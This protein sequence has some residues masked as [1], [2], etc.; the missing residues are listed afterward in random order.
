M[1]SFVEGEVALRPWPEWVADPQRIV[2]VARLVRAYDDVV[3]SMGV[4]DW[5]R[6]L[7]RPD[8]LGTPTSI[9]GASELIGHLDITP[10]NVVFR[11]GS[12][13]ALIDFDMIRP[14]SRSEE[15]SNILQWWAPWMPATDREEA[16]CSVDPVARGALLVD[17]YG[18]DAEARRGLVDVALNAANR[19]WH[20]MKWRGESL[21]GG[22]RRMWDSGAGER[23]LRRSR[24]I[25]DN[26]DELTAAVAPD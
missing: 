22:W 1:L 9:A 18:L 21:G 3:A 13:F 19:S 8:P 5:T 17:A 20:L 7:R 25:S 11:D 6:A 23:A 26:R 24:W 15:V 16:L 10:E 2:S 12:A 4:P 14:S